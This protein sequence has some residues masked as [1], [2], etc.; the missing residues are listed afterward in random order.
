MS[1][2]PSHDEAALVQQAQAGESA[3]F[4]ELV[5]AT[6]S[7]VLR[8]TRAVLGDVGEADDAAQE[9]FLRAWQHIHSL[10]PP[11]H[12]EPWVAQIARNTARNMARRRR[13]AA[14][15]AALAPP[16]HHDDGLADRIAATVRALAQLPPPLREAARLSYLA[17]HRQHEVARRLNVPLGTVKSRLANSRRLIRERTDVMSHTTLHTPHRVMPPITITDRPGEHMRVPLRGY[18]LAFGSVLDVGDV[19][20]V[21]FYDYPGG[22]LTGITQTEVRR[23][24]ELCGRRCFEVHVTSSECDPPEPAEL[25]YFQVRDDGTH[26]LLRVRNSQTPDLC[27]D[28]NPDVITDPPTP[29]AYDSAAPAPN[30]DMRVVDLT[31]GDAKKGRCLAVLE[32]GDDSTAAELFYQPTGRCVLHRRYVA[33]D[34]AYGDYPHLPPDDTRD[35]HGRLYRHWYDS[36]LLT[37]EGC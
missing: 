27:P 22:V 24:V 10:T 25:D 21:G 1:N 11:H 5:R 20:F 30:T 33:P 2:A 18:G 37:T 29:P 19:E 7:K 36:V 12:F 14:K 9:A 17:G 16:T 3:A 32:R 34:A 28:V 4:A 23:A 35:I 13:R 15:H 31:I 26:W 8:I 6:Q